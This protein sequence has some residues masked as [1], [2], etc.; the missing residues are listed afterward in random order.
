MIMTM[1]DDDDDHDESYHEDAPLSGLEVYYQALEKEPSYASS[2]EEAVAKLVQARN[3]AIPYDYVATLMRIPNAFGEGAAC[4]VC[5]SS[6]D[7]QES[8][9]GLDLTTC[10]G[11]KT[12]ATE[13]PAR[14]LFEP[15]QVR[16]KSLASVSAQQP[17]ALWRA[18]RCAARH[19]QHPD[20]Q[21]L[22]RRGR[23][24]R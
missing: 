12:G 13:E 3:I 7:P 23:Q 2:H 19:G 20:H 15:G 9:R 11:I 16:G 14:A 22:D 8:Y 21:D 1:I 6:S 10:E 17:H 24:E 4:V 5:H 18:V